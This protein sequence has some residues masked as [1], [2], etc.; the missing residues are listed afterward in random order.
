MYGQEAGKRGVTTKTLK[1]MLKKNGLKTTGRK[2]AL[3]RRAKK[4]HLTVGG[5][6][7]DNLKAKAAAAGQELANKAV[8]AAAAK[9]EGMANKAIGA[10]R[11][12]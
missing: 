6:F 8:D 3:T 11:R 2:A 5:G 7:M 9:A 10:R 1:R 12:R 4:A